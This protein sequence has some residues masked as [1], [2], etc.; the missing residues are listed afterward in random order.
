[1]PV[2]DGDSED[3]PNGGGRRGLYNGVMILSFIHSS[4]G[5]SDWQ[6]FYNS[7]ATASSP[8]D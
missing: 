6:T 4:I 7:L 5:V 8:I 3:G 2:S 1:M